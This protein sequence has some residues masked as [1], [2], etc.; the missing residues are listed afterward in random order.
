MAEGGS[1]LHIMGHDH[2]MFF[3]TPSYPSYGNDRSNWLGRG[4]FSVLST[5]L[6]G[7]FSNFLLSIGKIGIFAK[8]ALKSAQVD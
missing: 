3:S 4:H 6:K 1:V 7:L 2:F 8:Q 5:W